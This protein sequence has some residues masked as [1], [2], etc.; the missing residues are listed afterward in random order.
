MPS[1]FDPLLAL[2]HV[3]ATAQAIQSSAG[4]RAI[5]LRFAASARPKDKRRAEMILRRYERLLLMQL[6]VPPGHP[7]R[8]VQ[9]LVAGGHVRLANGRYVLA[10]QS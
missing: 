7:P 3:H 2:A 4:E 5:A 6:D 8:T 9:K 10:V 1:L